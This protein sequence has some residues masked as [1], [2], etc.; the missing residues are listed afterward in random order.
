MQHTRGPIKTERLC[1]YGRSRGEHRYLYLP[2][3]GLQ[4]VL[5]MK[6]PVLLPGGNRQPR[7]F[8]M[9]MVTIAPPGI[10]HLVPTIANAH[11]AAHGYCRQH[12]Q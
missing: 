10:D 9:P 2:G 12:Q 8:C 11:A 6:T 5:Y 4:L 7:L 3:Y 1:Q